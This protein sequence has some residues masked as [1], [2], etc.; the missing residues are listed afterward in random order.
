MSSAAVE[1]AVDFIFDKVEHAMQTVKE[2]PSVASPVPA[3]PASTP[4]DH[5]PAKEL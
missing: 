4:V 1:Y 5:T 3:G 2:V